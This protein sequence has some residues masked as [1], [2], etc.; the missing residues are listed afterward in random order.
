MNKDIRLAT[1]FKGHRKRKKLERI[2]GE[3]ATSHLVDLWISV[4]QDSPE[5]DLKGWDEEDIAYSGSWQE[6]PDVF[7]NAL[8]KCGFLKKNGSGCYEIHDWCDHQGYACKAKERSKQAKKAAEV[9]WKTR[10]KKE[11]K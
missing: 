4:A 1:S 3:R 8:L 9:R 2:L 6:E 7:V 5:G 11:S 10:Y